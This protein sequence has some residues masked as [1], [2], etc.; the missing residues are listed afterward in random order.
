MMVERPDVGPPAPQRRSGLSLPLSLNGYGCGR[1]LN[2]RRG[3]RLRQRIHHFKMA[4]PDRSG[5]QEEDVCE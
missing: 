4:I 5:C 1:Q 2:L 3:R